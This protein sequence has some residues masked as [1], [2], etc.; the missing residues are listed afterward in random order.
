MNSKVLVFNGG[1]KGGKATL[2]IHVC[3]SFPI[4]GAIVTT[5]TIWKPKHG[6]FGTLAVAKSRRSPADR[7]DHQI[8]S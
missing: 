4:S 1:E 8:Q 2:F 7:V 3:F 6:R 5:V